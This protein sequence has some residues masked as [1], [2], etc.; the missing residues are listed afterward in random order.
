MFIAREAGPELVGT[1][2]NRN[3][4]VN[5]D[6]IVESVSSGV[7]RA[8]KEA[9]TGGN[10]KNKPLEVNLYLDGKQITTT[11]ERVQ[12]ERGLSLMNGGLAY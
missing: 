2:G 5:N 8:V 3:A 11:V 7:Y 1:I 6:Q 10:T 9:M 4:V 12:R